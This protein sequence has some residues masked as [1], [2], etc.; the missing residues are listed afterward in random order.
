MCIGEETVGNGEREAQIRKE[1]EERRR[2]PTISFPSEGGEP[3][4]E[5]EGDLLDFFF[6]LSPTYH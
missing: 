6:F 5:M 2:N 1:G 4:Q 3:G